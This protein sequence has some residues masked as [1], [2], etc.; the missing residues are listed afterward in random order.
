MVET[1]MNTRNERR[2]NDTEERIKQ[3]QPVAVLAQILIFLSFYPE[4]KKKKLS[5]GMRSPNEATKIVIV[6]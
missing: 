6:H 1:R 4:K 2:I 3:K 5:T